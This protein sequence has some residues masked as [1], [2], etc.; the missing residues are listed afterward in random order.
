MQFAGSLAFVAT[1]ALSLAGGLAPPA[2]AQSPAQQLQRHAV[3]LRPVQISLPEAE[4][5]FHSAGD[6]PDTGTR[7]YLPPARAT[8]VA[9]ASNLG[10]D[11][12]IKRVMWQV[13]RTPFYGPVDDPVGLVASGVVSRRVF[14]IDLRDFH[15]KQE[16]FRRVAALPARG[17]TPASDAPALDVSAARA[18][19]ASGATWSPPA[20]RY[21]VRV[22]P[23]DARP[24][25]D[26]S[27]RP[28]VIGKP[29]RALELVLDDAPAP[30]PEM[31]GFEVVSRQDFDL[32]L[33]AF[34]YQ[35]TVT[36]ERW[37]AGCKVIP[38]DEGKDAIDV[39]G[40]APGA[41]VDLVNWA[42]GAYASLK[43][44]AVSLVGKL[45]PFVPESVISV[46]LDSALAAAGI[47]PSI[48]NVDQ[49]M[50]GGADYL[51]TQVAEQIPV[52]ASGAL[53][54]MAVDQA[55]EQIRQRTREA[56]L[57]TARQLAEQQRRSV[58]WCT[59]YIA[60]PYFEVTLRNAAAT[61][62]KNAQLILGNSGDLLETTT[63]DI[64]HMDAGQVFTLPIAY[65]HNKNVVV[66]WTS[67][68]PDVDRQR[69]VQDWWQRYQRTPVSFT[70]AVTE[71]VECR[72]DGSCSAKARTLLKTPTR[73]WDG[74][75]A[76]Q[77]TG[78]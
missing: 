34:R 67:Q 16:R 45:L 9:L 17:S 4:L 2:L 57:D 76:Y 36:I 75:P 73:L 20:P 33:V 22:V 18:A 55:R 59:R 74:A 3:E 32:R 19:M 43:K 66:R 41:L 51:A 8:G 78:R 56:L 49:L 14:E 64:A 70:V 60:D 62:A 63:V 65:R 26:P 23:V 68:L 25:L 13:S 35:P 1:L 46:A 12:R 53:A 24:S 69:A 42:S 6:I 39:I 52:P 71:Q 30:T 61:P 37:P 11:P 50:T 54:E 40:E 10:R 58:T 5:A 27:R 44:L 28:A 31:S 7:K 48:P 38:R 77:A 15:P 29:S 21:Y 47:P 72:G